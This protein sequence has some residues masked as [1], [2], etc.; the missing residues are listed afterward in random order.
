MKGTRIVV[1]PGSPRSAARHG[2]TESLNMR[3]SAQKRRLIL[4]GLGLCAAPWTALAQQCR[5]TPRDTLGPYYKSGAPASGELCASGSGG[6][7]KLIVTGRVTGLPSCA[8]LAGARVEVWQADARGEY[9]QVGGARDD[10][11]CLLRAR[12]TAD[13]AG[14]YRY[15]TILPGEYPGRPRHIHYRVSHPGHAALVTQLYFGSERDIP[16]ALQATLRR[17]A[18]GVW[19]ATFDLTLGR[20]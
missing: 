12:L 19:Q 11:R 17:D 1:L 14:Q 8:P 15:S 4:A 6:A 10:Q 5:V 13:G 9:T 2:G 3:L 16:E 18:Q 7:E 20:V